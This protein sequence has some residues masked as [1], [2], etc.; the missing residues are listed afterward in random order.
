MN[1]IKKVKEPNN[2]IKIDERIV[3]FLKK[4]RLYKI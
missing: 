3:I 1:I 4:I 2:Y